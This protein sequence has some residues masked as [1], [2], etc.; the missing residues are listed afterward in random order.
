MMTREQI[1]KEYYTRT[2]VKYD[3]MHLQHE[4][5]QHYTALKHI[6]LLLGPLGI[7]NIL[8]VGAGT[9]R[10]I[11][12]FMDNHPELKVKGIEPV[13][14][15][16][17]QAQ[18]GGIAR[19]TIDVGRGEALP[20]PDGS[21][22]AVCAFGVMHHVKR[23]AIVVGE[24]MRVARRA[25]FISDSN[26][27]GQGSMPARR[28]KLLLWRFGL[29]GAFNFAKTRGRGYMV[30]ESDGL[31]YSYS[32][33]D[34]FD[35]LAQWAEQILTVPTVNVKAT[36]WSHPLLTASHVLLCGIKDESAQTSSAAPAP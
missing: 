29:W 6:S 26:R 24:M 30:S 8:D 31:A 16:V 11:R 18:R 27:F 9:G 35:Q 20:Y 5:Q 7:E 12:Y 17:E 1:Q 21:F 33:Y 36:S 25:I 14:A 34:S 22:D 23:P 15:L 2:A 13:E 10:A 19:E 32:V 28:V 4:D 3:E